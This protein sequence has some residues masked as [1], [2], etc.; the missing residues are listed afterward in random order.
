MDCVEQVLAL[1][2]RRYPADGS[3]D[4]VLA[5]LLA[6]DRSEAQFSGDEGVGVAP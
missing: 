3:D 6:G 4:A 5:F 2:D 1:L